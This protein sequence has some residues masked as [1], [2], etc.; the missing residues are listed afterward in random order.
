MAQTLMALGEFRFSADTAAFNKLARRRSW[1]WTEQATAGGSAPLMQYNGPGSQE[2]TLTGIIYPHYRGGLGQVDA[3]AKLADS[4]IPQRLITGLGEDW[5]NWAI[6]AL[7][8][9][10][11]VI[12][13]RGVPLKIQFDLTLKSCRDDHR[14]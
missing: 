10:R 11:T 13:D 4:G 3:M 12:Y 9:D 6:M 14:N 7:G 2:I 5:G 1:R 8:E